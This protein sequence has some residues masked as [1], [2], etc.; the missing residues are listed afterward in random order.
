M[1]I[2]FYTF[3][4]GPALP[5]HTR[6]GDPHLHGQRGWGVLP[7]S[8]KSG[9][10]CTPYLHPPPAPSSPGPAVG[11]WPGLVSCTFDNQLCIWLSDGHL[12]TWTHICGYEGEGG[13]G[14]PPFY[15]GTARPA[16]ALPVGMT[17]QPRSSS[18]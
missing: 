15:S 11:D 2:S 18:Y 17:A 3:K 6:R 5:I 4:A 16:S 10:G 13:G 12:T 9:G 8:G 1:L 7:V 14:L